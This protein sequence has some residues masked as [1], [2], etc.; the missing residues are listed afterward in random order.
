MPS[1]KSIP[2]INDIL[3]AISIL[4]VFLTLLVSFIDREVNS[5]LKV[6]WPGTP[7]AEKNF[8]NQLIETL[9]V[10][11]VPIAIA[12]SLVTYILLPQSIKI[13]KTYRVV[14]WDFEILPTLFICIEVGLL[15]ITGYSY[16]QIYRLIRKIKNK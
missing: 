12:F 5:L 14:Y 16:R 10:K 2:E 9:L 4:L 7:V 15:T 11:S 3:A 1:N 8:K 13:C 6:V